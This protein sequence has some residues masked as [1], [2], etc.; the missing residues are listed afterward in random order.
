MVSAGVGVLGI[1]ELQGGAGEQGNRRGHG[2]P[3]FGQFQGRGLA[4]LLKAERQGG[5]VALEQGGPGQFARPGRGPRAGPAPGQLVG[6]EAAQRGDQLGVQAQGAVAQAGVQVQAGHPAV[7]PD[8]VVRGTGQGPVDTVRIG[9]V[10]HPAAADPETVP[11]VLLFVLE[12]GA[13]AVVRPVLAG[14]V[15][16]VG[17]EQGQA[18]PMGR[19]AGDRALL[20]DLAQGLGEGVLDHG[21]AEVAKG[22][23]QPARSEEKRLRLAAPQGDMGLVHADLVRVA[24]IVDHHP[25]G[26]PVAGAEFHAQGHGGQ[27]ESA[28]GA[29]RIVDQAEVRLNGHLRG[30]VV[31]PPGRW[32]GGER[33]NR[34]EG[35]RTTD[36]A[37]GDGHSGAGCGEKHERASLQRDVGC[38]FRV[39]GRI[40]KRQSCAIKLARTN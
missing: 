10:A 14:V 37:K 30:E 5:L 16:T 31:R 17:D 7:K 27:V 32:L 26:S 33:L 19:P 39:P 6:R 24:V 36:E 22:R 9:Q 20:V 35:N 3:L 25:A 23:V 18:Q 40:A 4:G 11:F 21:G 34:P 2:H 29:G 13:V 38:E 28:G 1:L 8:A 15:Q 12:R